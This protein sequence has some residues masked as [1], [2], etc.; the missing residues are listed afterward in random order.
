M[1]SPFQPENKAV[2]D[3][4]YFH[5]D[6]NNHTV[7]GELAVILMAHTEIDELHN[8]IEPEVYWNS[9]VGT[10][11]GGWNYA[12]PSQAAQRACLASHFASYAHRHYESCY[13][14]LSE[15]ECL[16]TLIEYLEEESMP[17]QHRKNLHDQAVI[18]LNKVCREFERA[19]AKEVPGFL[20]TLLRNSTK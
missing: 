19:Y 17:P 20:F 18:T 6:A 9:S 4:D 3:F 10:G 7:A 13:L 8:I 11:G 5:I 15:Y 16:M 2:V 12:C 1:T 14:A